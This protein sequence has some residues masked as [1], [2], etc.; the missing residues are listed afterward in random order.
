MGLGSAGPAKQPPLG[1]A[2]GYGAVRN[3]GGVLRVWQVW[4]KCLVL[5]AGQEV[6]GHSSGWADVH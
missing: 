6:V 5:V 1:L 2:Q 4:K 3:E